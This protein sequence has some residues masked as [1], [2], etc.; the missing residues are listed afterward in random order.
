MNFYGDGDSKSFK[1]IEYIY[2]DNDP[3]NKQECIGHYQT[4][5]GCRLRELRSKEHLGG[6]KGGLTNSII[7]RLQN[8]FGITL[9]QN[10]GNLKA[11]E[12]AIMASLFHVSN[13]HQYCPE[14]TNSWCLYQKDKINGTNTYKVREELPVNA[15]QLVYPIYKDLTKPELLRKCLH[16]KTQNANES[17]NGMIWERLPKIRYCGL[18]KLEMGVFD[19]VSNFNYGSKASMDIFKYFNIVPGAYMETMWIALNTKRIPLSS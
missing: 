12:D 1:T 10:V 11:M 13:F 4:R 6:K 5:V 14:T 18:P 9:R 7:D 8:Y 17:L 19:A 15:R 2:G 3:V 16:G